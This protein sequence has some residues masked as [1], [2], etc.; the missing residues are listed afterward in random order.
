MGKILVVSDSAAVLPDL[1]SG[2]N[3]AE[4]EYVHWDNWP[5]KRLRDSTPDL[6]LLVGVPVPGRA[7][8][9]LRQLEGSELRTRIM[10]ILPRGLDSAELTLASHVADD[11]V[12][13][14]ESADVIRDRI[15][16]FALP[17]AEAES[18]YENLVVTLGKANLVGQDPSFLRVAEKIVPSSNSD[19][20][21]LITGETGTGKDLFARAI[22]FLSRRRGQP[23]IPVD[24]AGIPDHLFENEL[25]GHARGAYTDA[26]GEQKGLAAL[27]DK[28]T[29][30]LD[31]IDSLSLAAQAKLLRFLQDHQFK[32]LGSERYV[33]SEVR[34][35]AA[36][37]RNLEQH[38][39]EKQ[40]RS[41]LY[42]RLNVLRFELPPL[43]QRARDIPLLA[44]HFLTMYL[45]RNVHKTFTSSALHRLSC[46][47]WPG[48]I[49]E[50]A[51]VIQR[52]I[53]FSQGPQINR[54][55]IAIPDQAAPGTPAT[56]N[57]GR[58]QALQSFERDY[59]EEVLRRNQGNITWAAREAGKERRAFGR[60][61]KK[62]AA[63]PP[64]P[65]GQ[66]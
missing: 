33:Y 32:P 41:D 36:T 15:L 25:F 19:F 35:I 14:P 43:C 10:A 11:V 28:G 21:A 48:N 56:F 60:L 45:P 42:F 65:V 18:A 64:R 59:V 51:N 34:V 39:V 13:L 12:L 31:E 52:A 24:C 20:P 57:T 4:W 27:A 44:Q 53:V 22:H 55:D 26:H 50:L 3:T 8:E 29:L 62:Y 49:R 16:R 17:D 46:Y 38:V 37:N 6:L 47:H 2:F 54:C 61:V 7:I 58:K 1:F 66:I 63:Q 5:I 30:F 40:F 9:L 23:F